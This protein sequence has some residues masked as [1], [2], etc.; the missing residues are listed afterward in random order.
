[1][2]QPDT[3]W[4][5]FYDTQHGCLSLSMGEMQFTTP[6]TYK[7]LNRAPVNPAPFD[8]QDL[9][10]YADVANEL[11]QCSLSYS[12][13]QRTQIALNTCAALRYHKPL[14]P[15]SWFFNRVAQSGHFHRLAYLSTSAAE[16]RVWVVEDKQSSC[17]CMLLD[18][19]LELQPG[20][21]LKQFELIR[22]TPDCL[23][24]CMETSFQLKRA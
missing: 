19:Q 9:E 7:A 20:K 15:K 24:P 5:W 11:E 23:L 14:M 1:M 16:V 6:Y 17:L 4:Q 21:T 12:A 2:L 3:D 18:P 13:A 8:L 22:V 10:H